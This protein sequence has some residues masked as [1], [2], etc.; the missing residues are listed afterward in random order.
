MLHYRLYTYGKDLTKMGLFNGYLKEGP[1][2]SKNQKEK[3]RFFLFFEL[4]GRKFSKL[5]FLNILYVAM[6]IPLIIGLFSSL[7]INPQLFGEEGINI[8]ILTTQPIIQ[9]SGNIPGMIIFALSLFLAGPATAG[10]TYV[11]RNFQREEHAWV[12][13]DFFE[14]FRKNFKQATAMAFLDAIVYFLLYVALVFYTF[15][16]KDVNPGMVK[17]TPV[18]IAAVCVIA[19]I[20][21]WMHFYIHT[22]MVTFDLKLKDILRNSMLFAIGKL[23]LNLLVT[24]ICAAVVLASIYY[25]FIGAILAVII[26]VSLVGFIIV[27][28][29]YPTID[30]Y[31]ITPAM[32]NVETD[33][34]ETTFS[35]EITE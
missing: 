18:L 30:N 35:D 29:V 9:F 26:T 25:I 23:P 16:L 19:I 34:T 17:L 6:L 28:S 14:H 22:M 15:M 3:H 21:T 7:M 10:F 1:G 24:I 8:A 11:I 2:V 32:A 12:L 4:F 31:L 5:I 27:F 13:S 20:Y 33:E